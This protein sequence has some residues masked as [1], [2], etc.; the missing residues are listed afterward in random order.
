MKTRKSLLTFVSL[1]M[2]LLM[3]CCSLSA[4][5]EEDVSMLDLEEVEDEEVSIEA[6]LVS[7]P[8]PIDYTGGSVPLEDGYDGDN[9]YRDP[10]IQ[11]TITDKDVSEYLHGYRGR[12]A[13]AWIV[14]IRIGDASQLRTAAAESFD[15]TTTRHV[16]V[17][18]DR[19]NAVVAFNGDYVNRQD[20]GYVFREGI[21]Y[22]DK[23]QGKQD[24]LLI[25]EDG[26][27]HTLHLPKKG[28]LSDTVDGKK[29]IN[30]FCAFR[31]SYLDVAGGAV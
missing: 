11:V 27:F 29:V 30:A 5:E 24:V 7:I 8:L 26:D 12:D 16:D 15:T 20:R 19:L 23:L 9:A 4:A 13:H 3:I 17:I 6:P 21:F 22:K 2:L 28:E 1:L 31:G 14:D 18:A 25:D 10:T